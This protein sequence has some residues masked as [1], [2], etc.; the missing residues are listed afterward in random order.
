MDVAE[1]LDVVDFCAALNEAL[2]GAGNL[3]GVH[4]AEVRDKVGADVLERFAGREARYVALEE[5]CAAGLVEALDLGAE[6]GV[7]LLVAGG[8]GL[9]RGFGGGRVLAGALSLDREAGGLECLYGVVQADAL[10]GAPARNGHHAANR[11]ECGGLGNIREAEAHH[12]LGELGEFLGEVANALV[13]VKYLAHGCSW[14]LGQAVGP[15]APC[16]GGD[17]SG[18]APFVEASI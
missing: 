13:E 3:A 6:R 2:L 7:C 16:R 11:V 17:A 8:V 9:G 12:D 4:V 14:S 10:D 5:L 18:L 1:A 15:G